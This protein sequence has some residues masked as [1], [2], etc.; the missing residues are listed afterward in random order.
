MKSVVNMPWK[1]C[2]D[3]PCIIIEKDLEDF[4]NVYCHICDKKGFSVKGHIGSACKE[5]HLYYKIANK[6]PDI[7]H[8]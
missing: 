8:D 2:F 1:S 5:C 3:K 4:N 6:V 7:F